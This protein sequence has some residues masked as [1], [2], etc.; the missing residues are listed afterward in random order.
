MQT[1]CELR[2]MKSHSY[3]SPVGMTVEWGNI[4]YAAQGHLTNCGSET[5]T[6][7][8][9]LRCKYRTA[10]LNINNNSNWLPAVTRGGA[11][12]NRLATESGRQTRRCFCSCRRWSHISNFPRRISASEPLTKSISPDSSTVT[13]YRALCLLP[14]PPLPQYLP[15]AFAGICP[16]VGDLQRQQV[17]DQACRKECEPIP[18]TAPRQS[19]DLSLTGRPLGGATAAGARTRAGFVNCRMRLKPTAGGGEKLDRYCCLGAAATAKLRCLTPAP[20]GGRSPWLLLLLPRP[21]G[22]AACGAVLARR[23]RLRNHDVAASLGINRLQ[24]LLL[25]LTTLLLPLLATLKASVG[26]TKHNKQHSRGSTQWKMRQRLAIV[27]AR[28]RVRRCLEHWHSRTWTEALKCTPIA[29]RWQIDALTYNLRNLH[30]NA[31]QTVTCRTT[32]LFEQVLL[33]TVYDS[34]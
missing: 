24:P 8:S 11:T 31:R 28:G 14:A 12:V 4:H 2:W 25:L 22:H 27:T 5:P 7:A 3:R 20:I 33:N 30:V 15:F 18:C 10:I 16:F 21:R 13:L 17:S 32:G 23:A 1:A 19:T 26:L 9:G 6:A 29:S 34:S